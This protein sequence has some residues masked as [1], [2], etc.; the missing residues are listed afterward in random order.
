MV[1]HP[2]ENQFQS[3]THTLSRQWRSAC[4]LCAR[5][6]NGFK[7]VLKTHTHNHNSATAAATTTEFQVNYFD[8][9][10]ETI[11]FAHH[12]SKPCAWVCGSL[13][14]PPTRTQTHTCTN[15]QERTVLFWLFCYYELYPSFHSSTLTLFHVLQPPIVFQ[16]P[17]QHTFHV[18]VSAF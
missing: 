2:V 14:K 16:P 6:R 17:F 15:G 7:K 1:F 5:V 18:F 3:Q 9:L 4:C 10:K 13:Q 12:R 11:F 8:S